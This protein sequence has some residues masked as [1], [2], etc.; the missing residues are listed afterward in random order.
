MGEVAA[1]VVWLSSAQAS[2]TTGYVVTFDD[3]GDLPS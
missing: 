2:A 1:R 3:A